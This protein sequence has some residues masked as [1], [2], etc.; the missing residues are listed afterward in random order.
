MRITGKSL[1]GV[2]LRH[3]WEKSVAKPDAACL[4]GYKQCCSAENPLNTYS[5]VSNC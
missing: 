2:G 3:S 5:S 1:V 4:S